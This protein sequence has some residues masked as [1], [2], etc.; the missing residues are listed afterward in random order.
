[1][2]QFSLWNFA[3]LGEKCEILWRINFWASSLK[4]AQLSH[5]YSK[6]QFTWLVW[7][8][9]TRDMWWNYLEFILVCPLFLRIMIFKKVWLMLLGFSCDG[10]CL[11]WI[12]FIFDI[13]MW[14]YILVYIFEVIEYVMEA[15]VMVILTYILMIILDIVG[16]DLGVYLDYCIV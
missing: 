3:T 8:L 12:E 13:S 2:D 15:M 11:S 14:A 4:L 16:I 7:K 6:L 1:M 10:T 5:T 9:V